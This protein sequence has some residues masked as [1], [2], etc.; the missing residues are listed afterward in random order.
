MAD[1]A[2][3]PRQT[4]GTIIGRPLEFYFGIRG[5]ERDVFPVARER[6]IPVVT[7]T[8]LRWK[9][10]L[11]ATPEDPPG[12]TPPSAVECYRFCLANPAVAVALAA[13]GNRSE[14][15]QD[16]A[17]LDDWRAQEDVSAGPRRARAPDGGRILVGGNYVIRSDAKRFTLSSTCLLAII[18][19]RIN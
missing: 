17:L 5:A 12:F 2:M 18:L 19:N 13:P 3:N 6:R 10:L 11:A 16:L 9:G 4:V 7:F 14:L 8:G 1:V 15:D